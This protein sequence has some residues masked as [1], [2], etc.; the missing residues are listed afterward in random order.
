MAT[1][2]KLL[3]A[4]MQRARSAISRDAA[5][6]AEQAAAAHLLGIPEIQSAAVVGLYAAIGNELPTSELAAALGARGHTLAYPRIVPG[7]RA[8]AFHRVGAS[9]ELEPGPLRILQPP[10]Q[11]VAIEIAR[12]EVLVIPGLAFD[13]RGCRLGRGQGY[14]DVTL[15]HG[16]RPLCIGYAYACQVVDK[17]PCSDHDVLMDILITDAGVVR[18]SARA[19]GLPA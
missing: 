12:I 18:A 6:R 19:R 13:R 1:A 16:Q 7:Q 5:A 11:A 4:R 8:L 17:V 9:S 10:A 14:Y 15:A 2:K 3:R